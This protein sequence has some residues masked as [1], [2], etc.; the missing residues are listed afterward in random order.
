MTGQE[1]V[2]WIGIAPHRMWLGSD[3]MWHFEDETRY[4]D[5]PDTVRGTLPQSDAASHLHRSRK[6]DS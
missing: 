4:F 5:A 3:D 6:T 1:V 2:E